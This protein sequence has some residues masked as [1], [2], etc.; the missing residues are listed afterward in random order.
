MLLS[1][2]WQEDLIL[3]GDANSFGRNDG[4]WGK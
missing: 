3:L 1:L 4:G 2:G